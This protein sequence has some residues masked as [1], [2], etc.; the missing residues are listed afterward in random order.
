MWPGA[1][2]TE[3]GVGPDRVYPGRTRQHPGV[4]TGM[5][6]SFCIL[7]KI[8]GCRG[9]DLYK[10]EPRQTFQKTQK[11]KTWF[12]SPSPWV[13]ELSSPSLFCASEH[14]TLRHGEHNTDLGEAWDLLVAL[15]QGVQA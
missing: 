6:R 15:M 12:Q 5:T 10:G 14:L 13:E 3:P 8:E 2:G 4:L 11:G 7:L 1:K 9:V